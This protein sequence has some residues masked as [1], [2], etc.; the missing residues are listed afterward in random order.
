MFRRALLVL[1]LALA[2]FSPASAESVI[3]KLGTVAPEGSVWHDGLL[4]IRQE[5]TRITNGDVNLR[6]Y[7]G[8]VLGGEEEMVRKL[9]RRGLDAVAITGAGLPHLDRSVDVLN[10]P[11]LFESYEE[12]EYVR[13]RVVPE[14]ERRIESHNF[15][16]LGWA[17]AGWVYLFTKAP[18]RLPNDL[19]R[20]RLW[21]SAGAP[22]AVKIYGE[23]GFHVVPL[24]ATDMLTGLQTGLIDAINVPPLFALLD[25]SYKLAG[26]MTDLGWAPLNAATVISASAWKRIPARHHEAL[27]AAVRNVIRA[28]QQKIRQGGEQAIA[29]MQ[30][31]GLEVVALDGAAREAWRREARASYPRMREI[32]GHPELFDQVLR[33]AGEYKKTNSRGATSGDRMP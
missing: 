25:R 18:V 31:R 32:S 20:L 8:G 11:L 1:L 16:V 23:L 3:I 14:L 13:S 22:D 24:P 12:L 15:K 9:E 28:T 29:E 5:W 33:L 26:H 4:Q 7:A 30:A 2:G 17:D 6:I 10:L 19:R 21:V 27:H